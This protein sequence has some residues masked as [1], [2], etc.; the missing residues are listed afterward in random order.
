M[1]KLSGTDLPPVAIVVLN[2]RSWKETLECLESL[3]T[4]DYPDYTLIVVDNASG[5]ES[6]EK[7]KQWAEGKTQVESQYVEYNRELKP[8]FYVEYHRKEAEAGGIPEKEEELKKHPPAR[9]MVLIKTEKNLGFSGG[10]NVGARYAYN[11]KTFKYVLLL[12]NDT[13]IMD[14][15]F[16][17]KLVYVTERYPEAKLV[18]PKIINFS[19]DLDGPFKRIGFLGEIGGMGIKNLFRRLLGCSMSAYI[20]EKAI[21]SHKPKEVYKIS[22]ACLFLDLNFFHEIGYLDEDL[23]LSSEEAALAEA[24][25]KRGG[26]IFFQPLTL[27]VHKKAASPRGANWFEIRK[28]AIKQREFFFKKYRIYPWGKLVIIKLIN[29]LRLLV[30]RLKIKLVK[31]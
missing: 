14:R 17:K 25:R 8:V 2:Y 18:G 23:W 29:R 21:M 22:G 10:N 27:L 3:Q 30:S 20:D 24:V 9:R 4:M 6:L 31:S 7:I 26:K 1:E 11:K 5:D 12:N 28:N 19:D 13:I 15:D 16:L